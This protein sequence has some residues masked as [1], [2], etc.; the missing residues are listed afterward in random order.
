MGDVILLDK[1]DHPDSDY[2]YIVVLSVTST[3]FT[4][5]GVDRYNDVTWDSRMRLDKLTEYD[6][7]YT[8]Y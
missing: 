4:F 6:T 5:A 1:I 3:Q 8:R 7:I 2:T